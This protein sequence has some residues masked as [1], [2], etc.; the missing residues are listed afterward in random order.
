MK[1]RNIYRNEFSRPRVDFPPLFRGPSRIFPQFI[2]G[3]STG[4]SLC[5]FREKNVHVFACIVHVNDSHLMYNGGALL[6]F[7]RV[8]PSRPEKP[9]SPKVSRV[10]WIIKE[11]ATF[12]YTFLNN[13]N[14]YLEFFAVLKHGRVFG[15][16][17]EIR[18]IDSESPYAFL[19]FQSAG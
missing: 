6:R 5:L 17:S 4:V 1:S 19:S 7:R 13:I 2:D 3:N 8:F 15:F 14:F 11:C 9:V 10:S 18:S 12:L 16:A